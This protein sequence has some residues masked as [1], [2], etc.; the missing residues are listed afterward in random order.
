MESKGKEKN[1]IEEMA[2]QG[3]AMQGKARYLRMDDGGQREMSWH[4]L[5]QRTLSPSLLP[6]LLRCGAQANF[7]VCRCRYNLIRGFVR[8]L[9]CHAT[10]RPYESATVPLKVAKSVSQLVS[11]SVSQSVIKLHIRILQ[12]S[13]AKKEDMCSTHTRTHR[14]THT[15][16]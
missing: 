15:L 12:L 7:V 9:L 16:K 10:S 8:P 11:Q 1:G 3:K 6:S 13:K 14:Y 5:A 4:S 2:R